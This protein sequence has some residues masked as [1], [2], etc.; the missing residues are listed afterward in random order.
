MALLSVETTD[1]VG[2]QLCTE[3]TALAITGN[4]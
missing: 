1:M 4:A 2:P 3:T